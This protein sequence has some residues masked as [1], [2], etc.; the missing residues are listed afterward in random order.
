MFFRQIDETEGLQP[1]L[2]SPHRKHHLGLF[3]DRAFTQMKDQLHL[4]FFI[5]W[6]LDVHQSTAAGELMQFAPYLA[7]VRQAN[8]RQYRTPQFNAKRPWRGGSRIRRSNFSCGGFWRLRHPARII[9]PRQSP[10]EV[11]KEPVNI[12]NSVIIIKTASGA[13]LYVFAG[14][15]F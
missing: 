1:S 13:Y 3:A 5:E 2:R 6:L 7:P 4:Q 15:G 14:M 8:Q 10:Q 9:A 11:T 12:L